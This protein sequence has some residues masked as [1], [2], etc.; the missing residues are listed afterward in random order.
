MP[1]RPASRRVT[2]A[3]RKGCKANG[4]FLSN[5]E[6]SEVNGVIDMLKEK[7][8]LEKE[9]LSKPFRFL[10]LPAEIRNHIYSLLLVNDKPRP[11]ATISSP[12]VA[13]ASKQLRAEVLPILFARVSWS[14]IV[15]ASLESLKAKRLSADGTNYTRSSGDTG[16]LRMSYFAQEFLSATKAV[17]RDV[18]IH[19][20]DSNDS[21]TRRQQ[22]N[23]EDVAT[24]NLKLGFENGSPCVTATPGANA[25]PV[26]AGTNFDQRDV[27]AHIDVAK[28]E[29][30]RIIASSPNFKGFT[31]DN[32]RKIARH[33]LQA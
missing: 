4:I 30:E 7:E 28:A 13:Q 22:I 19:V 3:I 16:Q 25:I 24:I 11:F 5:A 9:R 17:L 1:P 26:G 21:T 2:S 6:W 33:L 18:T 14:I 29:A 15:K 20:I 23:G 32:I 27:D 10:D 12:P 8:R 31:L